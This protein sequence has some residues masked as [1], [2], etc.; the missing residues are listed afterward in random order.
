MAMLARAVVPLAVMLPVQS[1][2]LAVTASIKP[3]ELAGIE[4]VLLALTVKA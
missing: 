3:C 2:V 4:I 1:P